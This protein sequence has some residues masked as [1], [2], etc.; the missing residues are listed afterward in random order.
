MRRL[1][2]SVVP[3]KAGIGLDFAMRRKR[4]WIPALAG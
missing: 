4:E 2:R 3:A 1:S